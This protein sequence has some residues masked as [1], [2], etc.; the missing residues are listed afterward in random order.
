MDTIGEVY[1]G[2]LTIV[3]SAGDPS[4]T[5]FTYTATIV[6]KHPSLTAK[7]YDTVNDDFKSKRIPFLQN[8]GRGVAATS[9]C[10][11]VNPQVSIA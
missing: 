9:R 1:S 2:D 6:A 10:K 5:L 4:Q 3:P 8:W 11:A 7:F